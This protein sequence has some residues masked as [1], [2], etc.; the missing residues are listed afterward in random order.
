MA[1]HIYWSNQNLI[2]HMKSLCS[3]WIILTH[4]LR[5]PKDLE[6]QLQVTN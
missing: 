2:G 6:T 3:V 5:I 1:K 4:V